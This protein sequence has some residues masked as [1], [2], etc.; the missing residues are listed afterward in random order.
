MDTCGE[1][2][3]V[4]SRAQLLLGFFEYNILEEN[5]YELCAVFSKEN[6]GNEMGI[7]NTRPIKPGF[8]GEM[9]FWKHETGRTCFELTAQ[10]NNDVRGEV[11][12]F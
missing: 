6:A 12:P 2:E 8:A 10:K 9:T 11:L 5:K 1:Q 4:A 3:K 7:E